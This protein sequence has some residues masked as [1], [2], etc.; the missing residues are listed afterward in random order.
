MQCHQCGY[1][2]DTDFKFCPECGTPA[3]SGQTEQAQSGPAPSEPVPSG[4]GPELLQAERQTRLQTERIAY[5]RYDYDPCRDGCFPHPGA[6]AGSAS[7]QFRPDTAGYSV[8][9]APPAAEQQRPSTAGAIV[10]A[11]VNILL[12]GFGIS[13]ILGLIALIETILASAALTVEEARRKLGLAKTLNWIGLAFIIL[14]ILVLIFLTIIL[15]VTAAGG[16][17]APGSFSGDFPLG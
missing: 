7:M 9:A 14:Q 10:F 6:A 11:C 17:P 12:F 4:P 3:L 8:V 5:V 16:G 13:L 15:I 1:L 2:S